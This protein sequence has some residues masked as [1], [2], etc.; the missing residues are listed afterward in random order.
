VLVCSPRSTGAPAVPAVQRHLDTPRSA[1]Y[2]LFTLH[3]ADDD[4]SLRR[5]FQ[6][7]ERVRIALRADAFNINNAVHFAAP[8][9]NID[10]ATFGIFTSMA[11]SPRKLQFSARISF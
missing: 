10:S 2:G 8:G 5:D 11:N 6:V 7:H 4:L 9:L 3:N 1:P